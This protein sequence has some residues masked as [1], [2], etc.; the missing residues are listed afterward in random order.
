MLTLVS[1]SGIG[2]FRVGENRREMAAE[3]FISK[4]FIH[5]SSFAY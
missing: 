3:L 5:F 2:S 4:G 1:T